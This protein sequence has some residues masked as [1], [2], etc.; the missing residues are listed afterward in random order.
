VSD[1]IVDRL[2][3]APQALLNVGPNAERLMRD[4]AEEIKRLRS[5]LEDALDSAGY[6]KPQ[7]AAY[8]RIVK[9][10]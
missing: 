10:P 8:K 3:D 9:G 5:E 4:A 1:D 6:L 2:R 7:S